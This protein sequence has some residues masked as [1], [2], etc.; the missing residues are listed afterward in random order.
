MSE[1]GTYFDGDFAVPDYGVP[2]PMRDN[3]KQSNLWKVEA[4]IRAPHWKPTIRGTRFRGIPGVFVEESEPRLAIG[5]VVQWELLFAEIPNPRTVAEPTVHNYQLQTTEGGKITLSDLPIPVTSYVTYDYFETTDASKIPILTA[6]RAVTAG[7]LVIYMGA[8]PSGEF[9]VAEN[10]Q[11]ERW[12][13]DIW[14]RR[15]RRVPAPTIRTLTR[16][17]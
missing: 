9:I 17:G 10:S 1:P 12:K 3:E 8:P 7:G 6:Y 4:T 11:I 14:E 16:G 2:Q 13:G 5:D 15:T